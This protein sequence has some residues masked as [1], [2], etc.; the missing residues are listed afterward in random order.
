MT[1]HRLGPDSGDL[2]DV[3]TLIRA[4]FADMAGRIDPPS[5]MEAMTMAS[6]AQDA[7][8]GEL[9]VIGAPVC[10][11]VML[12]PKPPVLY[13]G[14]LAVATG[15]RG[16]GLARLLIEHA[17]RRARGLGLTAL[18]LQTRIELSDNH[19]TFAALGFLKVGETAHPG[20]DRPTS[21]T[22]HKSL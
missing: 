4:A 7:A 11:C 5:S 8:R 6:L 18:E 3:L 2:P 13:V 10:A 17:E 20:Y 1:P 22:F 15:S 21:L 9:W 19:A 12:T 16:R 14:K